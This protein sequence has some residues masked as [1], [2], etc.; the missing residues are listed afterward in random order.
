MGC[1]TNFNK[2]CGQCFAVFCSV[3][4]C[5]AVFCRHYAAIGRNAAQPTLLLD[6]TI[7]LVYCFELNNTTL[8][9]LHQPRQHYS[10][11]MQLSQLFCWTMLHYTWYT[12]WLLYNTLGIIFGNTALHLVCWFKLDNTALC[13]FTFN[14]AT[15]LLVYCINT[16]NTTLVIILWTGQHYTTLGILYG[17]TSLHTYFIKSYNTSLGILLQTRE[18]QVYFC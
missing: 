17:I 2:S 10:A 1:I 16:D 11:G 7:H 12:I 3:L 5:F 8:G 13:I 9:I 14:W 6:N 4:Q 18:H 15:L